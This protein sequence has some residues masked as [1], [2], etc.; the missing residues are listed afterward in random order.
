MPRPRSTYTAEF[1][2]SAVKMIT[3]QKLSVAEAARR[4][5]VG[6]DLSR[7]WRKAFLARSDAA[8]P[9]HPDRG[10]GVGPS[11]GGAGGPLGVAVGLTAAPPEPCR[12]AAG[13]AACS[14]GRGNPCGS[15]RRDDRGG[16]SGR[17]RAA[18]QP[19]GIA[20][21]E[22]RKVQ[23]PGSPSR[24][25]RPRQKGCFAWL[26]SMNGVSESTVPWRVELHHLAATVK[27]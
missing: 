22:S 7:E 18:A 12:Q 21:I 15:T 8:F 25:S 13:V 19:G 9:V 4:L 11:G 14:A 20:F 5:D 23:D 3:G 17:R 16:D 27:L 6:E 2:L 1:K 26:H 24:K 10:V